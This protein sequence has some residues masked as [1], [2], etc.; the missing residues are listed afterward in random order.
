MTSYAQLQ[1]GIEG[2]EEVECERCGQTIGTNLECHNCVYALFSHLE[3]NRVLDDNVNPDRL[4]KAFE[5]L[6]KKGAEDFGMFWLKANRLM[7]DAVGDDVRYTEMPTKFILTKI[8]YAVCEMIQ[9]DEEKL[10][11]SIA[12]RLSGEKEGS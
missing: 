1:Q 7:I 3:K 8:A 6:H 10:I 4:H 9:K 11:S 5:E 2:G 12:G